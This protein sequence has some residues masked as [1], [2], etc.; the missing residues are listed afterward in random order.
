M[1]NILDR[2]V[3]EWYMVA[4]LT[5]SKCCSLSTDPLAGQP[6]FPGWI[7]LGTWHV[8]IMI[9]STKLWTRLD[10]QSYCP[11]KTA[12]F[13]A[14]PSLHSQVDQFKSLLGQWHG[15]ISPSMV[16]EPFTLEILNI[17]ES[18]SN[19]FRHL[20]MDNLSTIPFQERHA[21]FVE[22]M[23]KHLINCEPWVDIPKI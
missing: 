1:L 22:K 23:K 9:A 10:Y 5:N 17:I 8:S 3:L 16:Q 11:Y 2:S 21:D 18:P 19:R 20:K 4:P 14:L 13:K 12:I 6:F 7:A 15:H